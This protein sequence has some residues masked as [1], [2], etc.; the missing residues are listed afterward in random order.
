MQGS[1]AVV[2]VADLV[3][4]T[5]MMEA[6]RDGANRPRVLAARLQYPVTPYELRRARPTITLANR[7]ALDHNRDRH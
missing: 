5:C 2:L 1:R 3:G 4:Y 6:D 7:S